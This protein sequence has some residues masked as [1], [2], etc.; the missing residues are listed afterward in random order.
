MDWGDLFERAETD[1]TDVETIRAALAERRAGS[2]DGDAD[3][4][5][6]DA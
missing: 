2:N 5:G 4:E 6:E 1:E 3:R